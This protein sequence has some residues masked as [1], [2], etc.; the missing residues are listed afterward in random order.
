MTHYCCHMI[1]YCCHVIGR[2]RG[3]T[4]A[5]D[6]KE[7]IET[8]PTK[9][10]ATPTAD[11]SEVISEVLDHTPSGSVPEEVSEE[12]TPTDSQRT[13]NYSSD[14]FEVTSHISPTVTGHAHSHPPPITSSPPHSGIESEKT[15]SGII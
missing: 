2:S 15:T 14:S 3:K 5:N 6:P 4:A 1:H 13:T 9:S 11:E 8:T 12:A 7:V 10:L